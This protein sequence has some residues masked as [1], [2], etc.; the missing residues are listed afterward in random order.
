MK[1]LLPLSDVPV[2]SEVTMPTGSKIYKVRNRIVINNNSD[3][4]QLPNIIECKGTVFLVDGNNSIGAY[5]DT[6]EVLMAVNEFNAK[7]IISSIADE[8]DIECY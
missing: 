4:D 3:N 2:N 8:F 1:V 6:K 7:H 5:P